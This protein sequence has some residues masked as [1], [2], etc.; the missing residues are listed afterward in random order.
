MTD[1]AASPILL[2]EN[3]PPDADGALGAFGPVAIDRMSASPDRSD[4]EAALSKAQGLG[5]RSRTQVDGEI[6]DLA[7]NLLTVGCFCIGTNQVDLAAAAARGIPV[8]N[9]PFAN[10]RSV[11]ELTMA[12][13]I[14]LMRRIPEKMFAIREGQWLKTADGANEVR[15]KKL[16]IVGYGNIGAQLSVVASA[17]GMHVYY[18]DVEPKL[19]HGNARPVESLDQL[20]TECDAV[21]LHV[22][23]TAATRNMM[24]R[25]RI[26]RM[27]PGAVL[28]NQ[29]RGDLVDV[30]ALTE[31]LKSGHLSGAAVDVF[32]EE[33]KGKGDRFESPLVACPNVILT[34]HIGGSTAEAQQAIGIDAATKIAKF[35]FQGATNFAVNFPQIEPGPVTPGCVRIVV[36]HENR[37]GFLRRLNDVA[38]RAG[39][40]IRAQFL[41]T[42]GDL[43]YAIADLEG[44]LG[45]DFAPKVQGLE[46]V[47][48]ARLILG[49]KAGPV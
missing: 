8:F 29:A 4:L 17:L 15:K 2:L 14:M 20:L 18:Y 35:I 7:P 10:T 49:N 44:Q 1:T 28:I 21:T 45:A 22:P 47:V 27:K 34:P 6:L 46:G 43:G 5:I 31:A 37:P 42:E 13:L 16:G 24:S 30:D 32:P 33:P 23:S 12:S 19:A 11:A 36:P 39:A 48:S 41:Q 25:E 26:A 38:E 3:V 40:N 9:A